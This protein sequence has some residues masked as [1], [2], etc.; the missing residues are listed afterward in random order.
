MPFE[1]AHY[2]RFDGRKPLVVRGGVVGW[3]GLGEG[4]NLRRLPTSAKEQIARR[5]IT[6][7]DGDVAAISL[8]S[9]KMLSKGKLGVSSIGLVTITMIA[10]ELLLSSA[11]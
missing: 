5:V 8:R 1:G 7:I 11:E 2:A 3:R 10:L 4:S 6:T 9:H